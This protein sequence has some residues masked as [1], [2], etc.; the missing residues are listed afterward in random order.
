L[1][2]KPAK[3]DFRHDSRESHFMPRPEPSLAAYARAYFVTRQ[4]LSYCI[5]SNSIPREILNDPEAVFAHLLVSSRR[6]KMREC[7]SNPQNRQQIKT[8]ISKL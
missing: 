7:L 2:V 4:A 1:N 3:F 5:H 8:N 6:S